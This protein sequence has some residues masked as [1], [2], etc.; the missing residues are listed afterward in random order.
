MTLTSRPHSPSGPLSFQVAVT[1][2]VQAGLISEMTLSLSSPHPQ[3]SSHPRSSSHPLASFFSPPLLLFSPPRLF[4]VVVTENVQALISEMTLSATTPSFPS[5]GVCT[6]SIYRV[7][8][9][10][11]KLELLADFN[12]EYEPQPQLPLGV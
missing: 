6:C 7:V 11:T 2:N 4:Q 12:F 3:F 10:T 5:A 8:E 1:E 9:A